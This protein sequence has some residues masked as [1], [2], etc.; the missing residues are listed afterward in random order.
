MSRFAISPDAE[1][2]NAGSSPIHPHVR[3]ATR[4]EESA[5]R[6]WRELQRFV[7]GIQIVVGDGV[8]CALERRI[9]DWSEHRGE[10]EYHRREY[11]TVEIHQRDETIRI[12]R[13]QMRAESARAQ[14]LARFV[15]AFRERI[16]DLAQRT[17]EGEGL[18]FLMA[19][20]DA[21]VVRTLEAVLAMLCAGNVLALTEEPF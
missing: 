19:I 3:E 8:G 18:R 15:R 16:T 6:A 2:V 7:G 21:D 11:Q 20:H 17:N 12:L 14:D 5:A 13:G 1:E 4:H 10:A 9:E